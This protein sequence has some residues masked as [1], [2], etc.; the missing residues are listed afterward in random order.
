MTTTK[1]AHLNARRV[2]KLSPS[3]AVG[4]FRTSP[5]LSLCANTAEPRRFIFMTAVAQFPA[6][7]GFLTY[8]SYPFVHS[9]NQI[10]GQ[11]QQSINKSFSL[12]PLQSIQPLSPLWNFPQP[13][14]RFDLTQI[15]APNKTNY[16]SCIR[17]PQMALNTETKQQTPIRLTNLLCLT[18]SATQSRGLQN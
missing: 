4:V 12:N 1:N 10:R 8:V 11:H 14:I 17:Q 18:A 6:Y 9:N 16:A 7:K 2:F 13:S 5:R 3:L 15:S